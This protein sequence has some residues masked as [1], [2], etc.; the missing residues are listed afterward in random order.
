MKLS[1]H[2]TLAEFTTSQEA[3]RR[4]IS[5]EPSPEDLARLKRTA[6]GLEQVR[7]LLGGVPIVISSGYRTPKLNAMVGGARNSQHMTGQA[8]DIIVPGFG[9]P[10]V[11]ADAIRGSEI[12]YDQL[13]L[14]FGRWVHISFAAVPRRMN[15]VIDRNGSRPMWDSE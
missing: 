7:A 9:P 5:N 15:L 14:E 12:Q 3:E 10:K 8:A 6:D 1:T 2:F 13:I 11:V 4:G